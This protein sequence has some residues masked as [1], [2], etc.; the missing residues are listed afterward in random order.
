MATK[1]DYYDILGVT[2]G[3]SAEELKKAYRKKA[4]EFH[5]DKNKD[6]DAGAKFKE[7]NEAYEI[8]SDN[9]KKKAYDQFGHAAFDPSSGFGGFGEAGAKT[10]RAGPF[11]YTY[12]SSGGNPFGG[13]GQGDFSDP[14]DI[15]E[16]FFGGVNPFRRGPQKP[17]YSIKVGFMEAVRGVERTLVHQGESHKVKIPAGADN[18]TR[19]QFKDF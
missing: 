12:T 6:K 11:T 3:V 2:K 7:I 17:H 14:F 13:M 5:P 4:L 8:L 10:G 16:S 9:Q 1:R 19:I 18:G 15:F